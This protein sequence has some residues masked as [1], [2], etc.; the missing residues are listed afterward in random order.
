MVRTDWVNNYN[1]L[2]TFKEKTLD[3]HLLLLYSTCIL[4]IMKDVDPIMYT[5]NLKA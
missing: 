4:P 5:Y 2:I 3:H 1:Q